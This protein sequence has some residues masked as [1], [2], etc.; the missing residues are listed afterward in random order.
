M[1]EESNKAMQKNPNSTVKPNRNKNYNR[2]KKSTGGPR[3]DNTKVE[4][5]TFNQTKNTPAD[6]AASNT[7]ESTG[8]KSSFDKNRNFKKKLYIN[9]KPRYSRN[10]A[11]ETVDEIKADIRRIEKEIRLEIEEIKSLKV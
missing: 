6:R 11:E 2:Y 8:A 4:A 9:R 10:P 3:S 7:G 5:K 1:T